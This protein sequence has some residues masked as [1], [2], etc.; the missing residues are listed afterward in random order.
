MTHLL[1][2]RGLKKYFPTPQGVVRAVDGVDFYLDEGET[3]GLV[4]ES[5]SGK[6][7]VA[8]TIAGLYRPTAGEILFRGQE[9]GSSRRPRALRRHIQIVF[10]DPGTSLNPR[11]T[12]LEILALPLR[13]HRVVRPQ[14]IVGRVRE[15]LEHV[16]L[17]A[18]YL[19]KYPRE[20][21]E[22]EKQLVAIARALAVEPS[23]IVLDEPT[24]ALD[25]SMQ[26]RI[27]NLLLSL[28]K[29][30]GFA[31]LLITHDLSLMRNFATRVA[32]MYLGR[33]CETA[34]AAEFFQQPLHPYTRML[35]SAIPVVSEEE[36]A[37]K[38]RRIPPR[39]EIPS[40]VNPPPGCRFHTRCPERFAPCDVEEPAMHAAAP[41]HCVACHLY[42]E[43][44]AGAGRA[45]S[46]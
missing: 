29:R 35:L 9:I 8:Y 7:T 39:G 20:L 44:V 40:P 43:A 27:L 38:P 10:Q 12:V 26:A 28:Q 31:Y 15:L 23:L 22:G 2:V 25:V 32:I 4:G 45:A 30:F 6:T 46:P 37:L 42:A 21:S 16:Q 14:A 41:E 5:G 34:P 18:D 33:I 1:E 19:F 24:S 3:L 11:Q 36:E 17:P 13:V